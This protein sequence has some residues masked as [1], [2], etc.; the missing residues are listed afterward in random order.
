[1]SGAQ[2]SHRHRWYHRVI[3]VVSTALL[4]IVIAAVVWHWPMGLG[5][6]AQLVWVSG[7]SMEP[8]YQRRDLVVVRSGGDHEIGDVVLY[9]IPDGQAGEGILIIHRVVDTVERPDGTV[10]YITRGDNRTSTDPWEPSDDDIIGVVAYAVPF[11]PIPSGWVMIMLSPFVLAMLLGAVA[12]ALS[13]SWLAT[14]R[15]RRPSPEIRSRYADAWPA[16]RPRCES[17]PRV[18]AGSPTHDSSPW[19]RPDGRDRR[20]HGS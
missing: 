17:S 14:P 12:A 4:V 11:G 2:R 19:T 9:P 8:T 13:W 7:D 5:G 18:C 3:R 15:P 16:P 1:V 20:S 6:S 10:A